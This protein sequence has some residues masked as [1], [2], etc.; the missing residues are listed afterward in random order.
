MNNLNEYGISIL[1][2]K[3]VNEKDRDVEI[4]ADSQ[5]MQAADIKLEDLDCDAFKD[6]YG[7][8]RGKDIKSLI[9]MEA[10]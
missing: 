4:R 6:F 5:Y 2:K 1:E 8:W 3:E 10:E 7:S 9:S